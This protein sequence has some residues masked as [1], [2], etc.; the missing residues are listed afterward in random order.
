MCSQSVF[1]ILRSAPN[2]R[3]YCPLLWSIYNLLQ[4]E[5]NPK[6]QNFGTIWSLQALPPLHFEQ[7]LL[8]QP[9][10]RARLLPKK[11][12]VS[13]H[14]RFS[15]NLKTLQKNIQLQVVK[16]LP[17]LSKALVILKP[18]ISNSIYDRGTKNYKTKFKILRDGLYVL[19]R[20]EFLIFQWG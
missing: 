12:S 18:H 2:M 4:Q 8:P 6:V 1:P 7:R 13:L 16:V 20:I 9:I 5:N 15:Y 14:R 19:K 17:H 11:L 10:R 3:L